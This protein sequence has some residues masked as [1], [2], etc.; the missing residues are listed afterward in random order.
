MRWYVI[1]KNKFS[2]NICRF[3]IKRREKEII[4]AVTSTYFIVSLLHSRLRFMTSNFLL[5]RI[6]AVNLCIS[7]NLSTDH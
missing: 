6:M 7:A 4:I 5:H 2:S 1:Q 3:E